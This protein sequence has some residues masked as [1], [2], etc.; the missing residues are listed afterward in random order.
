LDS[1]SELIDDLSDTVLDIRIDVLMNSLI[2]K[3]PEKSIDLFDSSVL[4]GYN[5]R[6]M[7]YL[8]QHQSELHHRFK[9][10]IA[11]IPAT[12]IKQVV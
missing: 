9:K 8:E 2:Y 5:E 6:V 1:L 3:V 12:D 4:D 7:Y 10:V 11:A